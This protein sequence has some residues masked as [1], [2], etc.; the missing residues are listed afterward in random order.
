MSRRNRERRKAKREQYLT[1]Q[2]QSLAT[3]GFGDMTFTVNCKDG[4]GA[5][6]EGYVD[7]EQAEQLTEQHTDSTGHEVSLMAPP[8]WV[9]TP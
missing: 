1:G 3:L 2:K 9:P 5:L 7:A 4:C 8:E 6:A